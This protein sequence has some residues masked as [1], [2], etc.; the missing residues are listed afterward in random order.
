MSSYEKAPPQWAQCIVKLH[1]DDNENGK[2]DAC[3][4]HVMIRNSS[5]Y[6]LYS[7]LTIYLLLPFN[8]TH[9]FA[10]HSKLDT[11]QPTDGCDRE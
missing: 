4:L 3:R 1:N 7:L 2:I 6:S 10:H 5:M 9:L 8:I 11:G